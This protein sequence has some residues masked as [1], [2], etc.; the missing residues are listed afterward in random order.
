MDGLL[1]QSKA[2]EFALQGNTRLI[3]VSKLSA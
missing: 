1:S 2:S 3:S